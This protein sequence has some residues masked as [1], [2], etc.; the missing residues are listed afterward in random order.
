VDWLGQYN[1][2]GRSPITFYPAS[3]VDQVKMTDMSMEPF[4]MLGII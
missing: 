4:R 1:P 2:G 3:Y